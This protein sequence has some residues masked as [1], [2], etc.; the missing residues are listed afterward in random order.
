MESED[1]SITLKGE[2]NQC[3]IRNELKI[4]LLTIL[5]NK[6]IFLRAAFHNVR[7]NIICWA[8]KLVNCP[9]LQTKIINFKKSRALQV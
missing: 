8:Q 9:K 7:V 2:R 4:V 3:F 6:A 5:F 1:L